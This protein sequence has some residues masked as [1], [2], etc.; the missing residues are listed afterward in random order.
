MPVVQRRR[1]RGIVVGGGS[2]RR[3]L[4]EIGMEWGVPIWVT[5]EVRMEVRMSGAERRAAPIPEW[6]LKC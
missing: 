2:R 5:R 3:I 4:T 1:T 6:I